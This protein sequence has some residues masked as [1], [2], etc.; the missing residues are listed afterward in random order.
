M[1][2]A[3]FKGKWPLIYSTVDSVS[4]W[5]EAFKCF[6]WWHS[7]NVQLALWDKV[8]GRRCWTSRRKTN[9]F[10][11]VQEARRTSDTWFNF[12]FHASQVK[13]NWYYSIVYSSFFFPSTKWQPQLSLWLTGEWRTDSA[14]GKL[15]CFLMLSESLDLFQNHGVGWCSD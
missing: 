1:C 15:S 9:S 12:D 3:V 4:K 10:P 2:G 5:M 8:P 11:K 13:L 7:E 6:P 14:A